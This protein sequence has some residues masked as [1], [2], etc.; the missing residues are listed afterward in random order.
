MKN[1][2]VITDSNA[3]ENV[4]LEFEKELSGIKEIFDNEDKNN[5]NI[6]GTDIWR[7]K[8]Q[9]AL[10]GKY[11]ELATNYSPLVESIEI[12]IMFLKKTIEEYKKMDQDLSNQADTLAERLDVIS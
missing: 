6:D 1:R 3:F 11:K 5:A 10:C 4:I 7:G 2:I 9:Q 12:Y 8:M